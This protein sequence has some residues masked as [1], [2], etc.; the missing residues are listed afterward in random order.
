MA[1]TSKPNPP[2]WM[3]Y[4]ETA[5]ETEFVASADGKTLT[6]ARRVTFVKTD[7]KPDRP[8]NPTHSLSVLV[9]DGASVTATQEAILARAEAHEAEGGGLADL[10]TP[11]GPASGE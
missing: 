1:E 9:P 8:E 11:D 3:K 5:K 7:N 10:L 2:Y 6:P 4:T